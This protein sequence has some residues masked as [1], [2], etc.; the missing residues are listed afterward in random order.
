MV[1]VVLLLGGFNPADASAIGD[2]VAHVESWDWYSMVNG[3]SLDPGP[4]PY[5]HAHIYPQEVECAACEWAAAQ[6]VGPPIVYEVEV[7]SVMWINRE[8]APSLEGTK[9]TG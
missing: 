2:E 8:R 4:N 9:P 6:V 7:E 3:P 5:P 1:R